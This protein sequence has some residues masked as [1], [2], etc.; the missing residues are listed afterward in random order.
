MLTVKSLPPLTN[1]RVPSSGST[2]KKAS[3]TSGMRPADTASS[4]TT[5]TP[6][7]TARSARVMIASA[8]R[9]AAVTGE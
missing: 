2:R 1:S 6:G 3:S 9:S 8:S 4:A 7:A 5:G